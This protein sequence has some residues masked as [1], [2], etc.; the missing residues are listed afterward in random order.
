MEEIMENISWIPYNLINKFSLKKNN[1]LTLDLRKLGIKKIFKFH[2]L[3]ND[4]GLSTQL[5]SFGFREPLNLKYSHDFIEKKDMVLDLGAN[6]GLFSVLS[7]NAKE[8]VAVEPI[9]ECIP[10]LKKNLE[11]N[12]LLNKS[13]IINMAV[14]KKGI[15][16]LKKDDK[17]NLS[18]VVKEK[19]KGVV[20]VKSKPLSYFIKKYKSNVLRIDV[21]GYEYEI[22]Y[23]KIPKNIDKIAMEFHTALLGKKKV[24]E[25]MSY[26]EKEGFRVKY[27]LEDLPI[28]LYPFYSLLKLTSLLNKFTYVIKN[29]KPLKCLPSLYK[30]RGVKYLFLERKNK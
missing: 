30:G 29:Q 20:E 9:I 26:F 13:R 3:D 25:L 5:N 14:G 8:I 2:T 12:G 21:E 15:L 19:G 10:V 6:V 22:L 11:E 23:K 27:F 17:V 7:H 24:F 28:R 18:K 4:M 1:P 16:R